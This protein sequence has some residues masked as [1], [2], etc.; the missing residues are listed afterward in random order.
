MCFTDPA[1]LQISRLTAEA[2]ASVSQYHAT[3]H[4]RALVLRTGQAQT[5]QHASEHLTCKQPAYWTADA[6]ANTSR[7]RQHDLKM[8]VTSQPHVA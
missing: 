7:D 5:S 2:A 1:D 8:V 6:Q 3:A 4:R